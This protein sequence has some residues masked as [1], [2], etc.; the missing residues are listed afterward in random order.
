MIPIRE[1]IGVLNPAPKGRRYLAVWRFFCDESYDGDP[2]APTAAPGGER[3]RVYTPATFVVAGFLA[4]EDTWSA[5]SEQWKAENKKEVV[6]RYHAVDLNGKR[7]E[8]EGWDDPRKLDY[9]R[10]L[11]S[12]I[13]EQKQDMQ[14]IACG[15]LTRD[16]E[17]VI[18]REGR[19]RFGPPYIACFKTVVAMIAQEMKNLRFK[20]L[21][22]DTFAVIFDHNQYDNEVTSVFLCMKWTPA[23]PFGAKLATCDPGT[24]EEYTEL[25]VADFIAYETFKALHGIHKRRI[26]EAR[27]S[28]RSLFNDNG[29][30]SY[31]FDR[32]TLTKLKPQ[33]EASTCDPNQFIV[34]FD[35]RHD[36]G[37][38]IPLP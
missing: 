32:E 29:F 12:V 19:E 28:L 22:E 18:S 34:Q 36:M 33:I 5:V 9:S 10:R 11:L 15:I 25:Q 35:L 24:W 17:A 3:G 16:Y 13:R 21:P 26:V 38:G 6:G 27:A 14:A 8:Y 30:M 31:Y 4:N 23:Y 1:I 20:F 7:Y 2:N 37:I